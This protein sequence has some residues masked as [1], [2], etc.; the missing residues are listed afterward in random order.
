MKRTPKAADGFI[1]ELAAPARRALE[2]AGLTTLEKIA[3]RNE[4]EILGLHGM[5]PNAM[6]KLRAALRKKGLQ[7]SRR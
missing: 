3:K 7:F 1:E 6:G 2:G 4:S 5:G